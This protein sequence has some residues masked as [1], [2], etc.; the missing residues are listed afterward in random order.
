MGLIS[1][2]SVCAGS[3]MGMTLVCVCLSD[4]Q[5]SCQVRQIHAD[6]LYISMTS[7]TGTMLP[8]ALSSGFKLQ[9][10]E[11]QYPSYTVISLRSTVT[12]GPYCKVNIWT[13]MKRN[14]H[15]LSFNYSQDKKWEERRRREFPGNLSI[16]SS[17]NWTTILQFVNLI[18]ELF[19]A[20]TIYIYLEVYTKSSTYMNF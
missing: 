13:N 10:S 7:F 9:K 3:A 11:S 15:C 4:K 12:A 6:S 8:M 5:P 14:H 1:I 16:C 20:L 2:I 17:I 19:I 18:F